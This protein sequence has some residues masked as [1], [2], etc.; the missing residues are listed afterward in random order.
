MNEN[1]TT[2]E[3][4][5]NQPLDQVESENPNY[6]FS[7]D[8]QNGKEKETKKY[9]Y[10]KSIAVGL[11]GTILCGA[12]FGYF[13]GVGLNT[14]NS[15]ISSINNTINGGFSFSKINNKKEWRRQRN[16]HSF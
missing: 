4:I 10:K 6:N 12:S 15:V 14:S 3:N 2:E 8:N 5:L 7:N 1:N 13:L 16:L 11:A 9:T